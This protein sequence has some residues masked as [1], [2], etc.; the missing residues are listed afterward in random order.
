MRRHTSEVKLEKTGDNQEK[1]EK[2]KMPDTNAT[3]GQ[4]AAWVNAYER[5]EHAHAQSLIIQQVNDK[6]FRFIVNQ[7]HNTGMLIQ[8]TR[9]REGRQLVR[10]DPSHHQSVK[11]CLIRSDLHRLYLRK[12]DILGVSSLVVIDLDTD[13]SLRVTSDIEM[14]PEH[15]IKF[16]DDEPQSEKKRSPRKPRRK[17]EKK[18]PGEC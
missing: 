9:I 7:T 2:R 17:N 13:E 15:T 5:I 18:N 4:L 8:G 1:K 14:K 16:L 10:M 12:A 11:K 6:I 3:F